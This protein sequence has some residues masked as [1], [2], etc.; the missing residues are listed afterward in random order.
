MDGGQSALEELVAR[1]SALPPEKLA[2]IDK[3][4]PRRK[5]TPSPGPQTEAYLSKADVM[6]YGGSAGGG[7]SALLLGLALSE[8]KRSLIIR[9]QYADIQALTE[10]LLRFNGSRDGFVGG[11]RPRLRTS[12]GRLVEFGACQHSGDEWAW[13]GQPHDGL[14]IDECVHL[15]E[16]QVRNLMG[17]VRTTEKGQRCRIVMA[18][19]PPVGSQ[20]DWV[21]QFFAPWLDPTHPKP[22]KSGELRWYIADAEGRDKEVD[23]PDPVEVSGRMQTPHS[24]TVVF[25]KLSDNPFLAN[26]D[27]AKRLDAMPE[28][29]RSAIRDGNFMAAKEDQ[30]MQVIPTAWV[31]EAQARWTPRPAECVPMCAIGVDCGG[32]GKDA[33]IISPR[34][35]GWF[36]PLIVMK[37]E[38]TPNGTGIGGRILSIRRDNADVVIDAGGGYGNLPMQEIRQNDIRVTAYKGA[39]AATGRTADGQFGFVNKRSQVLWRFR[40]ALD[41]TQPGGS[42]IMLPDDPMLVS[43]LTAPTYEYTPRGI[44]VEAKEDVVDKLG[45]SPDRGDAVCLSWSSGPR[46]ASDGHRWLEKRQNRGAPKVILGYQACKRR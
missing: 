40:E 27:Y 13:Q 12:D 5:F 32:G 30:S 35:D 26:T 21:I 9:R 36:A 10:E 8:H 19:N 33:T 14:F 24:R 44:K 4:L 17:W 45:R 41:P 2:E 38:E 6:L 11:N 18:S 16:S 46:M 37:P 42:P 20:G 39:E 7:K 29:L 1:L 34:H 3:Q 23:G 28:P 43:D 31:K 22:A 25:A 15:L